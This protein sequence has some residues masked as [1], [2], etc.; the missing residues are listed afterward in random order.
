LRTGVSQLALF[1]YLNALE[2]THAATIVRPWSG[3]RSDRELVQTPK[4]YGFDTGF[5]CHARG[6]RDLRPDDRGLLLEHLVLESLQAVAAGPRPHD[7]RDKNGRELDFVL[8]RGERVDTV[9]VKWSE[10]AFDSKNLAH[11]RTLYP[12]GTNYLVTGATTRAATKRYGELRVRVVPVGELR[13]AMGAT[14]RET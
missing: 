9:E 3:G 4:V 6:L 7:W 11:F 1:T 13:A 10:S 2:I 8:P 5:V 12:E 14:S